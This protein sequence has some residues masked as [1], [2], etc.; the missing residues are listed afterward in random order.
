VRYVITEETVMGGQAVKQ[1]MSQER[2]PLSA[3]LWRRLKVRDG[4]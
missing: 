4:A 1:S 2:A 3:H